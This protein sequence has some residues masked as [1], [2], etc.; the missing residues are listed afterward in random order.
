MLNASLFFLGVTSIVGQVIVLR[1]LTI[2]FYGNE[3]FLG[4]TLASWL[5][6]VAAG[7]AVPRLGRLRRLMSR[8]GAVPLLQIAAV[9]LLFVAI[10]AIRAFKGVIGLPGE[11]PNLVIA[12]L[13]GLATPAPVCLLLG[14]WWTAATARIARYD[15]EPSLAVS[16]GYLIE[17]IGFIAG[18]VLASFVLVAL[19]AFTVV[20]LLAVVNIALATIALR[21]KPWLATVALL[22]VVLGAYVLFPSVQRIERMSEQ[23]RFGNQHILDIVHSP[24]GQLA[25]TALGGQKNF[26]ESGLLIGSDEEPFAAEE[27]THIPLLE[28]PHPETVLLLGGGWSGAL[29][30]ILEHGVKEVFYLELDPA[31]IALADRYLP[32][33]LKQG[34]AHQNVHLVYDDGYHFLK[35]TGMR[36]DAIIITLPAP[37]T[38]LINRYFTEEFFQLAAKRLTADGVLATSLP[39]APDQP[40]ISLVKLDASV[41]KA[42]E[43]AFAQVL[44]L[45]E[46]DMTLLASNGN[47]LTY[48]P[49]VLIDRMRAR[50]ITNDFVTEKYIAY[51]LTNDRIEQA[52]ALIADTKG[53][54]PNR[55]FRPIAYF[56]QT[57]FWLDHFYPKLSRAFAWVARHFWPIAIGI[58]ALLSLFIWKRRTLTLQPVVSVATAGFS[59]MASE[60]VIIFVYQTVVGFLYYRLA[61]LI[62]AL[63]AGMALGVWLANRHLERRSVSIKH[64]AYLHA[65]I[66]AFSLLL[67]PASIALGLLPLGAAQATLLVMAELAGMLGALVFP[68]ANHLYLGASKDI[69]DRT[70]VIYSAD[71]AGSALGAILPSVIIVPLFGVWQALLFVALVN[72]WAIVLVVRGGKQEA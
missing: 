71:V 2:T 48:E 17:T 10:F 59:L 27:I 14:A 42:L 3:F 39:F 46:E 16:R 53:T 61:L 35:T 21:E 6:W 69:A 12:A 43:A 65:A 55:E 18:G 13:V 28:H 63:M 58:L 25:V 68:F 36:F 11:I 38:A 20:L 33:L 49:S 66:I 62:A 52:R 37:S 26:F 64:L 30:E 41:L 24:F 32:P 34:L 22:L 60:I 47:A 70:G 57:L 4:F 1:E 72:V 67:Y 45:P 19:P 56:Y 23:F 7:S 44:M 8:E 29:N 31:L 54:R 9:L 5:A 51:R 40:T 50:G 15:A